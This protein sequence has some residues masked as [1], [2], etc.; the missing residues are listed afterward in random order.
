MSVESRI[1]ALVPDD[2]P[3][4]VPLYAVFNSTKELDASVP[5]DRLPN[6]LLVNWNLSVPLTKSKTVST[7]K[8]GIDAALDGLE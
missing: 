7:P 5:V 8:K 3:E 1:K 6:A 4:F 2:S